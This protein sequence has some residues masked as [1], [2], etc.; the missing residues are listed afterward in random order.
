MFQ[1]LAWKPERK[2]KRNVQTF[3]LLS[4]ANGLYLLTNQN[5]TAQRYPANYME[6]FLG[7]YNLVILMF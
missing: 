7:E 1:A 3:S 5:Q 2:S 6:S 4:L